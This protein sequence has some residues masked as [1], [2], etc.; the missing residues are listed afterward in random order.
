MSSLGTV[1]R[2]GHQ[3]AADI[4]A[5]LFKSIGARVPAY[6]WHINCHDNY[7]ESSLAQL[8]GMSQSEMI[9]VLEKCECLDKETKEVAKK[10][11]ELLVNKVGK[12]YCELIR[13]R[14]TRKDSKQRQLSF[15]RIGMVQG[16]DA[17]TMPKHLFKKGELVK[18]PSRSHSP[19]LTSTETDLLELLKKSCTNKAEVDSLRRP[20]KKVESGPQKEQP[21]EKSKSMSELESEMLESIASV[22]AGGEATPV[23]LTQRMERSIR[24]CIQN[25]ITDAVKLVLLGLAPPGAIDLPRKQQ[26]MNVPN[27]IDATTDAAADVATNAATDATTNDTATDATATEAVVDNGN[28]DDRLKYSLYEAK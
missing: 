6:C 21:A 23:K 17:I 3:T 11:L 18:F 12:D 5:K 15:L 1:T 9:L 4:L 8:L 2:I 24:R 27:I 26:E 13:Y 25:Y 16:A 22:F 14:V 28:L 7:K 10:G 19:R 20:C